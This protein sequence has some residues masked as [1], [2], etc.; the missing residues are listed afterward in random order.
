M[1]TSRIIAY[2]DRIDSRAGHYPGKILKVTEFGEFS[3]APLGPLELRIEELRKERAIPESGI[4]FDG[5]SGDGRVTYLMSKKGYDAY[6]M[7]GDHELACQGRINGV[8][9]LELGQRRTDRAVVLG[10]GNFV[11][12]REYEQQ[13][14]IL[15]GEIKLF[16][17]YQSNGKTLAELIAAESPVGTKY[18]YLSHDARTP[19][20]VS[21]PELEHKRTKKLDTERPMYLRVYEKVRCRQN[22]T[23]S[24]KHAHIPW[25]TVA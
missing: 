4:F 24:R 2:F 6:G 23:P 20:F 12:T 19:T 21:A 9:L 15:I 3:P 22:P 25:A 10:H 1:S 5:G 16:F 7:E 17:N 11:N 14:G 13:L 8:R 18:L